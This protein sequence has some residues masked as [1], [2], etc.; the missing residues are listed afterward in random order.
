VKYAVEM[1]SSS[2]ICILS[3]MKTGIG[4]QAIQRVCFGNLEAV[5]LALMI[6][7]IYEVRR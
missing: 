4:V 2:I 3:L 1:A 5:M 7:E 6:G